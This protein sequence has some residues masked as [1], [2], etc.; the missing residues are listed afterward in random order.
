MVGRAILPMIPILCQIITSIHC[1]AA[2]IMISH[3]NFHKAHNEVSHYINLTLHQYHQDLFRTHPEGERAFGILQGLG[4]DNITFIISD[5]VRR[6]RESKYHRTT[7][8]DH[9]KVIQALITLPVSPAHNICT[10]AESVRL[11]AGSIQSMVFTPTPQEE[12]TKK[13][14]QW[15]PNLHLKWISKE[16]LTNV[17]NQSFALITSGLKNLIVLK[18]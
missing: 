4:E 12:L 6:I 11:S 13:K 3:S 7:K 1:K 15:L 18:W 5:L 16:Y 10:R 14:F 8:E 17:K 9:L 2:H